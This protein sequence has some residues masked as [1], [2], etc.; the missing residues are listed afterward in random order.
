MIPQPDQPTTRHIKR[1][2]GCQMQYRFETT[3]DQK[4]L[5]VM[6]KC[7]RKT[8]LKSK[9]KRSHIFGWM[10]AALA[11]LLSFTS[12]DEEF[13]ITSKTVV[14]WLVVAVMTLSLLFEDQINGF[15]AK[16]RLLKGT[17]RSVST[18]D[19]EQPEVFISETS[20]GRS[21]FTYDKILTVAETDHYFVFVFSENHAQ[22]YAQNGLTGGTAEE[23]RQFISERTKCPIAAVK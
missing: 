19:T 10:I 14:T 15:F 6:A 23:F 7:I 13:F 2:G 4:A 17:E 18:F 3:Y 8:V 1:S 22:I 20:I 9:S 12:G 5:S 11:M 16:K 21:E